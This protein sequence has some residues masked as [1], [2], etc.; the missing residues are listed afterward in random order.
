MI[1]NYIKT[2]YRNLIKNK[3]YSIINILGLSIGLACSIMVLL[4]LKNEL[5]Y[6]NMHV[7]KKDIYRVGF[8]LTMPDGHEK[9]A[10]ITA[11]VAPSLL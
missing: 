5:T 10:V 7:H 8:N 1:T 3:T 9:S 11:V 4:Y 2:A 6:D